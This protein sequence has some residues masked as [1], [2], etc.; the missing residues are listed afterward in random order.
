[1]PHGAPCLSLAEIER[2]AGDATLDSTHADHLRDCETCRGRLN[3]ARLDARLIREVAAATRGHRQRRQPADLV[4]GYDVLEEI[5]RGGQ[6]IVYRALHR[7]TKR[8]VALK[9][10]LSGEM[11]SPAQQR[12]FEREIELVAQLRHPNIVTLF[13]AGKTAAGVPGY[14]M[15]YIEGLPLDRFVRERLLGGR[16]KPRDRDE[17]RAI[18]RLIGVIAGAV[19]YAHQRGII[20]RDLKPANILIDDAAAPHILDF[21]LGRGLAPGQ[22]LTLDG[23][24]AGTLDYAAPEQFSGVADAVDLRADIYSIGVMLYELLSG[25]SPRSRE[26]NLL[27]RIQRITG[28]EPT[29]VSTHNR[30]IDAG[31][32]AIAMRCLR[33]AP[34]ERYASAAALQADLENYLHDRPLEARADSGWYRLKVVA[35][36]NRWLIASLAGTFVFLAATAVAMTIL[37]RQSELSRRRSEDSLASARLEQARLQ[38][39]TGRIPT[40]EDALWSALLRS[41]SPLGVA[42]TDPVFWALIELYANHPCRRTWRHPANPILRRINFDTD[43]AFMAVLQRGEFRRFSADR[44]ASS[45]VFDAQLPIETVFARPELQPEVY[46]ATGNRQIWAVQPDAARVEIIRTTTSD[47]VRYG[48]GLDLGIECR[49]EG[50]Q[51]II[52]PHVAGGP[53]AEPR[54][55]RIHADEV[56]TASVLK[57]GWLLSGDACGRLTCADITRDPPQIL[58]ERDDRNPG[59]GVRASLAADVVSFVQ[60]PGSNVAFA[61]LTTGELISASPRQRVSGLYESVLDS[62]G[63]NAFVVHRNETG[64]SCYR[65]ADAQL[66]RTLLG[67]RDRLQQAAISP[68]DRMLVSGSEFA[69]MKLWD[70]APDTLGERK[71]R[72]GGTMLSVA[73]SPDGKQLLASHDGTITPNGAPAALLMDVASFRNL[74]TFE[75]PGRSGLRAAW[76]GDARR[77]V[78]VDSAGELNVWDSITGELLRQTRGPAQMQSIR[79]IPHS[80]AVA[81]AC[82]DGTPRVYHADTGALLDL[83]SQGKRVAS[84]A[85]SPDGR[86]AAYCGEAKRFTVCDLGSRSVVY[87]SPAEIQLLRSL[88][89]SPDG[90]LLAVTGDDARVRLY[91][92][93]DWQVE[94][95]IAVLQRPIFGLAFRPDGKVL[96]TGDTG[97]TIMLWDLASGVNLVRL[98]RHTSP[99][100]TLAYSPDGRVLAS[101]GQDCR[102]ILHELGFYEQ[103]I[104]GNLEAALSRDSA[105]ADAPRAHELR[106]W[107]RSLQSSAP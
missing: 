101:G 88:A 93:A 66:T 27:E 4:P 97:G 46:F 41:N 91:R 38:I 68:D 100:F 34:E 74:R 1:M 40:A 31:I 65:V 42:H 72:Y 8:T 39:A 105:I 13:D 7:E 12:R 28:A 11:Q 57:N 30:A 73:F 18:V 51:L 67:H 87:D 3:A 59:E 50:E 33:K 70:I 102:L 52:I 60:W 53:I 84:I 45:L 19:A 21:G 56:R 44:D 20:H 86:L 26:G 58:W 25:T 96:A 15:E 95:E 69:E 36:R 9:L 82:Y 90:R 64:V 35:R 76:T 77:V 23:E 54:V 10:P 16:S 81:V 24:F 43:R 17:I 63:E 75:V 98:D 83:P 2:L 37:Y 6:G 104:A 29:Q 32:E 71:L 14:A 79:T 103:H 107:A 89:F 106:E 92:T 78:G 47:I 5:H 22:T 99:V 49:Y 61:R 55:I 94:R 80:D 62:R 48:G 85:V